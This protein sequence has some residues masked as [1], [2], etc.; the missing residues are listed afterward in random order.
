MHVYDPVVNGDF[1]TISVANDHR[2]AYDLF[3]AL[4]HCMTILLGATIPSAMGFNVIKH[5]GGPGA[6][7]E[8][9]NIQ[10]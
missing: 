4:G 2:R 5:T 10:S 1:P 6:R 7:V 8:R 9:T 3:Q